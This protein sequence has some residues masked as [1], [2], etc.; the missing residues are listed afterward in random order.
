MIQGAYC[1]HNIV[2]W[3]TVYLDYSDMLISR[4]FSWLIHI[5]SVIL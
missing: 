4:V 2:S 5:E 3:E 1:Y